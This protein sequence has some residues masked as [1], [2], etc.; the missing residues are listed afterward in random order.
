VV[1]VTDS[2][3][4]NASWVPEPGRY[5][6]LRTN[7]APG[8][9]RSGGVAPEKIRI[10]GFPSVQNSQISPQIG[11]LPS[12]NSSRRVLYM[13][14]AAKRGAAELV[15]MPRELDLDLTSHDRPR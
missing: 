9:L 5:S 14:T 10:F 13:I 12:S 1:V 8:V 2:I 6:S 3:T 15:R 11:P 7:K 4:I